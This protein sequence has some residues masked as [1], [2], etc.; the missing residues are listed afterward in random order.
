MNK[1]GIG[2][3]VV[4]LKREKEILSMTKEEKSNNHGMNF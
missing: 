4:V 2:D 1:L 3:K